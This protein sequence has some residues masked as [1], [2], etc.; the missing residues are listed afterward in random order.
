MS[1]DEPS[2]ARQ[3]MPPLI[4]AEARYDDEK[5]GAYGDD[6]AD[7]SDGE[8]DDLL[9]GTL[10]YD[11]R[12]RP[13]GVFF[14]AATPSR[15][16]VAATRQGDAS[17]R[18]VRS[19]SPI[20][21]APAASPRRVTTEY[22]HHWSRRS[23]PGRHY[24][25]TTPLEPSSSPRT[26]RVAP[27]ASPRLVPTDDPRPRPRW[28][29]DPITLWRRKDSARASLRRA[30]RP[31]APAVAARHRLRARSHLAQARARRSRRRRGGAAGTA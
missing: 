30:P 2:G 16:R 29:R 1:D 20:H 17:R 8:R 26:I 11:D 25:L 3:R 23:L 24:L 21:V 13:R 18:L 28:R 19:S 4:H 12:A 9:Y 6:A 22:P 31:R 10:S 27:A 7:A 14:E 5:G 15:R